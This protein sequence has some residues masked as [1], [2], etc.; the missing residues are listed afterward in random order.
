MSVAYVD[1][2]IDE[3]RA[4][5][6]RL[7]THLMRELEA[8]N[9]DTSLSEAGKAQQRDQTRAATKSQMQALNAKELHLVDEEIARLERQLDA[10]SGNTSS[11]L[12][13]FRDAQD[14]ADRIADW[15][16]ANRI[17]ERA[18]RSDDKSLAHAVFRVA[19]EKRWRST[20]E[21]FTTANPALAEAANDLGIWK[22]FR[23][24]DFGRALAYSL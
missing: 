7:Q 6:T 2:L 1:G 11:D 20:I 14:R 3:V 10:K 21:L 18:L 24:P 13:A 5:A 4:E 19:I 17:L 16:E 8:I 9:R 12:I 15:T 22:K 23:E